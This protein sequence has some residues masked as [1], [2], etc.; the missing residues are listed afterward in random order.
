MSFPIMAFGVPS[1]IG[2]HYKVFDLYS[3]LLAIFSLFSFPPP[4]KSL[5]AIEIRRKTLRDFSIS[6]E[7]KLEHGGG[8]AEISHISGVPMIRCILNISAPS[9]RS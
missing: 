5:T 4:L 6:S 8:W 1:F 9:A 7:K 3:L 2:L